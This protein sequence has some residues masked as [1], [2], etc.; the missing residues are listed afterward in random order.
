MGMT[1]VNVQISNPGNGAHTQTVE[2]L[3]DT[4]A[5][6]SIVPRSLLRSA[7]IRPRRKQVF[8]LANGRTMT[9]QVGDALFRYGKYEGAAPVIFGEKHDKALLGV[10]SIEAMGL[11]I[12]PVK[13]RLKPTE[14]L[15]V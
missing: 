4:G 2:C 15:L 11:E 9:R 3:V 5:F 7:G 13:K 12:D 8:T 14:L 1:H 10:L 6:F